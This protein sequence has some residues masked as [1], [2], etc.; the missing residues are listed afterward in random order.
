LSGIGPK[1]PTGERGKMSKVA[2]VKLQI[3]AE[4]PKPLADFLTNFLAFAKITPEEFWQH[5][6]TTAVRSLLDSG[7][8]GW[9]ERKGLIQRY[10][11]KQALENC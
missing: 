9:L 2:T 7:F 3:S 6:V 5:E 1:R 11:L 10:E 4:L 8:C